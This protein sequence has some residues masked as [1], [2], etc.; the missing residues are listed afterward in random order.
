MYAQLTCLPGMHNGSASVLK[1]HESVTAKIKWPRREVFTYEEMR[2]SKF[3]LEVWRNHEDRG[4][5]QI[6]GDIRCV[7]S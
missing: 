2:G 3:A 1:F 7:E 6:G 5:V 4:V